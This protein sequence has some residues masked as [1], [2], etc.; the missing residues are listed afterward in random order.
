MSNRERHL[1]LFVTSEFEF[2]DRF[3]T[4]SVVGGGASTGGLDQYFSFAKELEHHGFDAIFVADFLGINRKALTGNGTGPFALRL[5]EPLTRLAALATATSSIGLLGTFSTQ[6]TEPYNLARQ[7]ASLD[8]LSG[9]R[10]GWNVVTSFTGEKNFGL[11]ELPSPTERYERAQEFLDVVIAL[12]QSWSSDYIRERE[13]GS[14]SIDADRIV[15]IDHVGTFFSVQGALDIPPS[16]QRVPVIQQAG[17]SETGTAFAAR[18]AEIVYVATPDLESAT[19]YTTTVKRL[20]EELGRSGGDIRVIPGV[21][22]YLGDSPEAAL[23]EYRAVLSEADL[24]DARQSV[25]G[26][27][28]GLDLDG[29]ELDDLVPIERFPGEEEIKSG[30]RRTSRALIYRGWVASGQYPRLREFL[31]RYATS[32]GHAQFIGTPAQVADDIQEWFESGAVDG[33]TIHSANSFDLVT[34][35][36]LPLLR[37]RGVLPPLSPADGAHRTLRE[38]LGTTPGGRASVATTTEKEYA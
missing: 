28:P 33:F 23:D 7:L 34:T 2:E 32:F 24:A 3:P 29:L 36:L 20:A 13:D 12:W 31:T 11:T 19:E 10:A 8:H 17:S 38:R 30:G 5:F 1:L 14:A 22:L 27:L 26:E 37:E 21:R 4:R 9:G 35:Q 25:R 15:D 16:P 18:N 6:F